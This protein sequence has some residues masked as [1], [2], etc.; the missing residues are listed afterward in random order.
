MIVFFWKVAAKSSIFA[1]TMAKKSAKSWIV[2]LLNYALIFLPLFY[3]PPPFQAHCCLSFSVSRVKSECTTSGCAPYPAGGSIDTCGRAPSPWWYPPEIHEGFA[4][5]T[6]SQGGKMRGDGE[7]KNIRNK[8][9]RQR[10]RM[11]NVCVDIFCARA[12]QGWIP[13]VVGIKKR[14]VSVYVRVCKDHFRAVKLLLLAR[15]NKR[16]C[17]GAGGSAHSRCC[18]LGRFLVSQATAWISAAMAHPCIA[19]AETQRNDSLC[20]RSNYSKY[21]FRIVW[22][23]SSLRAMK[24][25]HPRGTSMLCG[26]LYHIIVCVST[27]QWRVCDLG[28]CSAHWLNELVGGHSV[29]QF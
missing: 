25:V 26:T 21:Y 29:L 4:I 28:Y 14:P 2:L 10:D 22:K 8:G 23:H 9:Y 11:E 15:E 17:L 3:T 7:R 24:F 13:I 18:N 20:L 5:L 27:I 1:A 6:A 12:K 16:Q 19:R